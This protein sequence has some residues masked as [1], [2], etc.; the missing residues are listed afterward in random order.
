MSSDDL[1]KLSSM[2]EEE[3][4]HLLTW[5]RDTADAEEAL[6]KLTQTPTRSGKRRWTECEA[7]VQEVD[8]L[9]WSIMGPDSPYQFA[10]YRQ[11]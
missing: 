6:D 10:N 11:L 2:S 1:E 8:A 7:L 4:A 9:L 5:Y 3:K